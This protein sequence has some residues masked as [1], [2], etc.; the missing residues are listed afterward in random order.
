M[1]TALT[2]YTE[3]FKKQVVKE[4]KDIGNLSLV[5]KTHGVPLSTA[6]SWLN[7]ERG[8]RIRSERNNDAHLKKRLE[9]LELE[10]RVLKELLKKTNQAWLKD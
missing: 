8:V 2:P 6:H 3:D 7:V 10:N 9:S 1:S 5:C 4:I